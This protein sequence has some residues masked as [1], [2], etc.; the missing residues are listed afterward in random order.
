M[1][2]KAGA[3]MGAQAAKMQRTGDAMMFAVVET[4]RKRLAHVREPNTPPARQEP[5]SVPTYFPYV[6]TM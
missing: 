6:T 5:W 3:A 1:R 2:R 4:K